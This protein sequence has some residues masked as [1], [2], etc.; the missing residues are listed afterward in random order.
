MSGKTP[1]N[2]AAWHTTSKT[3]TL[4][5]GPAPYTPPGPDQIAIRNGA[6]AVNP[7][8]WMLQTAAGGFVYPH[9]A[10]KSFVVGTDVS[11]EVIAIGNAITRFKVGDRVVGYAIGTASPPVKAGSH[12]S[13]FQEYTVLRE[14]LTAPIPNSMS[15][16]SACVIPMGV[17]TASCGLFQEDQLAL[18]SPSEPARESTGKILLVW[19]GSTSVGCNAIQLAVAAGYE[20]FTTCSPKNFKFVQS[21]GASQAF[22]YNSSTVVPDIINAMKGNISAGA[23]SI[24]SGAA[25]ACREILCHVNGNKFIAMATYP[26]SQKPLETFVLPRTLFA[27]ITWNIKHWILCKIKGVNSKFIFGYTLIDNGVG[28]MLYEEYLPKALAH[29]SFVPSPEPRV[30]G[31]GVG[32]IQRAFD[33]QREGVSAAK[34]VVSM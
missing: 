24:G 29:G 10:G 16:E 20:V 2:R 4:V 32:S 8:D 31:K 6:V 13:A 34:I 26:V 14:H 11:G 9:L 22:D 5:V 23:Y 12:E 27:L 1:L 21:L 28:K 15:F 25:D 18:Q 19:G 30:V 17:S 3:K 33:I 7:V